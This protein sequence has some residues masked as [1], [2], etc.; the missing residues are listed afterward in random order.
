MSV[1]WSVID[2]G[3][4]V[5][6]SVIRCFIRL[7]I[8]TFLGINYGY[9]RRYRYRL[10]CLRIVFG[11]FV[12]FVSAKENFQKELILNYLAKMTLP[13]SVAN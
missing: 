3:K 6:R 13:K 2:Y 8:Q 11:Y 12:C 10:E 9:R 1:T 5:T 7:Q 4:S